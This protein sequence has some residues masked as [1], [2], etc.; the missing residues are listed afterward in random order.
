M[1]DPSTRRQLE[2][3]LV[4]RTGRLQGRRA[5]AGRPHEGDERP[6]AG[7]TSAETV[8]P[9]AGSSPTRKPALDRRSSS[10]CAS[11]RPSW[12][13]A[14]APTERGTAFYSRALAR[15]W[16][17][18]GPRQVGTTSTETGDAGHSTTATLAATTAQR[19]PSSTARSAPPP[20]VAARGSRSSGVSRRR[21]LGSTRATVHRDGPRPRPRGEGAKEARTLRLSSRGSDAQSVDLGTRGPLSPPRRS[22]DDAARVRSAS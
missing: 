20:S 5:P 10:R 12:R 1:L 21:W 11:S 3:A 6:R 17:L 13:P 22:P 4:R 9:A 8:S 16:A 7:S 14:A 19:A 2:R 15:T 18:Q